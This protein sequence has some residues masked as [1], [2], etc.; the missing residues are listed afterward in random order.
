[1]PAQQATDNSPIRYTERV[2]V[3]WDVEVSL[4][5]LVAFVC[6]RTH[7]FRHA[8]YP[9]LCKLIL[10]SRLFLTSALRTEPSRPSELTSNETM[11]LTRPLTLEMY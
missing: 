3:F 6:S 4:S 5:L 9:L 10:Q 1:M 7:W 8:V 11:D 2:G